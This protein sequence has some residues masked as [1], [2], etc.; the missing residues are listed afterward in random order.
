MKSRRLAV[1][2][3]GSD[4][5]TL[6]V[7]D[8]KNTN[9][10]YK[11]SKT[12]AGFG[13]GWFFDEEGLFNAIRSLTREC[14][15]IAGAP[16]Y[17]L[18]GVPGEFSTVVCKYVSTSFYTKRMITPDDAEALLARGD[19][20]KK[21]T[22][23]QSICYFPINYIL[24]NGEETMYPIGKNSESIGANVSYILADRRFITFF[25]AIAN[26]LD[27]RFEFTSSVTSEVLHIIPPDIRDEGVILL[28]I[29]YI[30]SVVAFAKGDGIIHM[31]TFSLGLGHIAGYLWN[32]IDMPFNHALAL[33]HKINLNL[34]SN[35][36][37]TYSI[38]IDNKSYVYKIKTVNEIA[39][40]AMSL[41]TNTL[42]NVLNARAEI[43][44]YTPILLT[45]SGLSETIGAKEFIANETSRRVTIIRPASIQFDKPSQSSM[46]GLMRE[47]KRIYKKQKSFIKRFFQSFWRNK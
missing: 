26:V 42:K 21:H 35:D 29:G 4:V 22:A 17:I 11:G 34:C 12:Y 13:Q 14:R 9:I 3:I 24:D 30:S 37:D 8:N 47:Q 10:L 44:A 36:E 16:E 43:P 1:L 39:S 38:T 15:I 7:Q 45:G 18:V 33:S 19:T 32:Y 23:F 28:D 27:M 6:I 31:A 25:D 41:I 2:D 46:V 40:F 5:I 20:Y